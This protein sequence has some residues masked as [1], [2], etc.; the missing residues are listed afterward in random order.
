VSLV[1]LASSV[2]EGLVC[3]VIYQ[4]V[5]NYLIYPN[6]MRRSVKVSDVAAVVAAL[7]GVTLFG[8]ALFGV[9]LFGVACSA[10]SAPWWRFRWWP[11][12]SDLPR[13]AHAEPGEPV[14]HGA[15]GI[16]VSAK[17]ATVRSA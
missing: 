1:G 14:D 13:G 4:R 5:E 10:W 11:A 7:L 8:V 6:V 15:S 16:G 9:A 2:T 3:I 17:A 12:S